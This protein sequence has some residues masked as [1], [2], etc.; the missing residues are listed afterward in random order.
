MKIVAIIV[1]HEQVFRGTLLA[2]GH[3][4]A[5][6]DVACSCLVYLALFIFSPILALS[7]YLG[8]ALGTFSGYCLS[9]SCCV[10][11]YCMLLNMRKSNA[12]ITVKTCEI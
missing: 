11:H 5:V 3:V 12:S 9:R 10:M 7:S 2:A 4:W 1:C 6:E 8:A